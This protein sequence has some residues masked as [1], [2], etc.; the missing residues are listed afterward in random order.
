[1]AAQRPDSQ[2]VQRAVKAGRDGDQEAIHFLYVRFAGDLVRYVNSFVKDHHEAEDVVH[3]I[4]AKLITSLLKYEEKDVPFKAWIL[5][6]ARNAALDNIRARRAIPTENVRAAHFEDAQ[7]D[8]ER[9]RNVR[10]AI[11]GLPK[12]Q[13]EVLVLRHIAGFSPIEIAS[14]LGRSE[15]SVHGLHHRGRRMLQSSLR[16]LD[17]TPIVAS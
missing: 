4:F 5:R 11:R 14:A 17:E 7:L 2:L 15:S 16:E 12:E 6:V 3:N 8:A 13:R 9:G 1:M 10:Q